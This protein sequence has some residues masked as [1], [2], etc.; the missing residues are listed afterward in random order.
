MSF[1]SALLPRLRRLAALELGVYAANASFFILLSLFPGMMLLIGLLQ[2]T[3][4]TPDDLQAALSSLFPAALEPLLDYMTQELFVA[5][6]VALVSFSAVIALWTAS[7]GA[8]SLLRGLNRVYRLRERRGWLRIR[9]RCAL[10]TLL[11]LTAL[12][13][14]AALHLFGRHLAEELTL[15]DYAPLRLLGALLRLKYW[16]MA[17]LL[18]GLF[19][20]IYT[21]LPDHVGKPALTLPGAAL[22]AV[23]WQVFS[24]LFSAYVLRFGNYSLYY[25]S[26]S[27]I[28]VAM[29]WLYVCMLILFLG[30]VLNCRV[31]PALAKRLDKA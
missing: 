26:L 27:A 14:T 16:L 6:S 25:G 11:L 13:L 21:L 3:P 19:S 28:A 12:V 4:L 23:G 30:A 2:Y 10:F 18:S 1:R 7:K 29:L 24:A 9:L 5:N 31:F 20:L 8:Y 15:S 17:L 22:A